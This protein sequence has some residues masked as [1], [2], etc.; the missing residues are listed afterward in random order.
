LENHWRRCLDCA[1]HDKPKWLNSYKKIRKLQKWAKFCPANF[2]CRYLLVEAELT[3]IVLAQPEHAHSLYDQAIQSAQTYGF[4]QIEALANELAGRFF[5]AAAK[6]KLAKIYLIEAHYLYLKWGAI[7]KVRNLETTYTTHFVSWN[8]LSPLAHISPNANKS[9]AEDSPRIVTTG[10]ATTVEL[11]RTTNLLDIATVTRA[12]QVLSSEIKLDKLLQTLMRIVIENAGADRGFLILAENRRLR[13]AAAGSSNDK[14]SEV[15]VAQAGALEASNSEVALAIVNYV[16][17]TQEDVVL[18]DATREGMFTSDPYILQKQPRSV[19]CIPVTNQGRMVGLLYLENGLNTDVFTAER[20]TILRV[21]AAQGAISIENAQLYANLEQAVQE[22]DQRNR[23][24][25]ELSQA[26]NTVAEN[27]R[28][29]VAHELHDAVVNP[30][31]TALT[32]LKVKLAAGAGLNHNELEVLVQEGTEVRSSLR[33]G[34]LNLHAAELKEHGLYTALIY[35]ARRA[36]KDQTF[37]LHLELSDSLLDENLAIS[38]NVQ[39]AVY[40]IAQQA[41]QNII[42]HAEARNVTI[43]LDVGFDEGAVPQEP[44]TTAPRNSSRATRRQLS[45][46]V[47]DDGK[48]FDVPED[49][50]KLQVEGHNGLAGFAQKVKLLGGWLQV[51]SQ[52]G[53]GTTISIEIPLYY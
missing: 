34:L 5:L 3:S 6:E 52:L 18:N 51:A 35:M 10:T 27:E 37:K 39:H 29:S 1:R 21:L 43:F 31:E 47:S 13:I 53:H 46:R 25:L 36:A 28:A 22:L 17:H 38:E 4:T 7:A 9:K 41:L 12:A 33:Q 44:T 14:E 50:N 20:L 16:A 40:R 48:G 19:L 15:I 24:L 30:F 42:K 2:K 23:D 11:Q 26:V 45:L 49:F 32:Q 8:V